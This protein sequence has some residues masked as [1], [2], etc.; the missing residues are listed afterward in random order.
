MAEAHSG[1]SPSLEIPAPR[2]PAVEL[3]LLLYMFRI[4]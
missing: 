1:L 2:D 4:V 3:V